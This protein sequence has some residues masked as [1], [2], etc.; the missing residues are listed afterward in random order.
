MVDWLIIA[1]ESDCRE[2]K[3]GGGVEV[4]ERKEAEKIRRNFRAGMDSV[5]S[6]HNTVRTI[7]ALAF[8]YS[9]LF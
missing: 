6:A 5:L 4:G 7:T 9:C 1:G 2:N 3:S 8:I